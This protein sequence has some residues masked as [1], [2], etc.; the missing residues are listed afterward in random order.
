MSAPALV[1]VVIPAYNAEKFVLRAVSSVLEQDYAP[2]EILLVDDGSTDGTADRVRQAAPQARIV[3]QDNAGVAAARNTGL[4]HAQGELICFLDADDG[5]FPGKVAAQVDYLRCQ[6][7]VGLVFHDWLVWRPDGQGHYAEPEK[8]ASP[9]A[10]A[11]DPGCS[12]WIYPQLLLECVVHTSTVMIRREV[13]RAVGFFQT[14]LVNGEDYDYW[15]RVSRHCEIHKLADVY[16]F[17]REVAGSLTSR[18]QSRNFEYQV[19]NAA[20]ARWGLS[21]P[22]GTT[23]PPAVLRRRLARLAFDFGYGHFHRGSARL[24]RAAF[25]TT[26]RHRPFNGRAFLYWLLAQLRCSFTPVR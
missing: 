13:A 16:S 8:P 23:L 3:R 21:S 24:A 10:G 7:Q 18:P 6:P 2:I 25:A 19:V 12:G 9:G 14:D 1:S 26:L 22:C 11:I 15:L 20:V 17:Y 4:R 5:W